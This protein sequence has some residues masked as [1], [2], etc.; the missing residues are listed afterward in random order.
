MPV[1]EHDAYLAYI[2]AE[3]GR[4]RDALRGAD[5]DMIVP[6]CPEWTLRTL[7]GHVGGLH[8]AGLLTEDESG[9]LVAEIVAETGVRCR[10]VRIGVDRP[11][12]RKGDLRKLVSRHCAAGSAGDED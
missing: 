1:L 12:G 11:Y 5:L 7:A 4:L 2:T 9:S 6:T 3:T 10:L 8:R